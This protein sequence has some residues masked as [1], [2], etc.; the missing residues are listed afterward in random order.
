MLSSVS[1]FVL[2]PDYLDVGR[3]FCFEVSV[4]LIV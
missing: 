4:K 2:G 1:G 3:Y